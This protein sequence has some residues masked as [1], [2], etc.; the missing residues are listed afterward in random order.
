M[1]NDSVDFVVKSIQKSPLVN[2]NGLIYQEYEDF[3]DE[4]ILNLLSFET[5]KVKLEKFAL[6]NDRNRL[7]V[8]HNEKVMKH[9]TI[10]FRNQKIKKAIEQ[11]FGLKLGVASADI[12]IDGFDYRLG[13][14][15]DFN[16]I[17]LSLQIYLGEERN[18]GTCLFDQDG[19]IIG[20]FPY[21]KNC[22]YSL[23]NSAKSLHGT[24]PSTFEVNN[25]RKSIYVR[26]KK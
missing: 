19:K 25:L 1:H 20:T 3:F 8:S 2:L 11:I 16:T 14:H 12:W 4:D 6:Q 17:Q 15:T 13:P 10:F 9:I 7:S 23:L 26:W 18:K 22:G 24:E 21:K 5:N